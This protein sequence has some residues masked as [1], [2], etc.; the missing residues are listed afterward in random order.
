MIWRRPKGCRDVDAGMPGEAAAYRQAAAV[1]PWSSVALIEARQK[2]RLG[3]RS[4]GN[5]AG[6]IGWHRAGPL[7]KWK[8]VAGFSS[9]SGGFLWS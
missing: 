6:N 9:I 2:F 3:N 1:F 4:A 5:L 7:P 8:V